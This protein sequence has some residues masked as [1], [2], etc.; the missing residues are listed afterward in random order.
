MDKGVIWDISKGYP[1]HVLSWHE[2]NVPKLG[3]VRVWIHSKGESTK[4][5]FTYGKENRARVTFIFG[6]IEIQIQGES[7][8]QVTENEKQLRLELARCAGHSRSTLNMSF[9]LL[10]FVSY[11]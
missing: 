4:S 8:S 5:D 6:S 10:Y 9:Q 1:A 7:F 2:M 11:S 3:N